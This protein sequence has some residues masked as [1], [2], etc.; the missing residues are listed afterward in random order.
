MKVLRSAALVILGIAALDGI[1]D[2]IENVV[3]RL[4]GRESVDLWPMLLSLGLV[5]LVVDLLIEYRA[6]ILKCFR[7]TGEWIQSKISGS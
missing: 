1:L 5:V 7:E 3:A 2:G 4:T 6:T